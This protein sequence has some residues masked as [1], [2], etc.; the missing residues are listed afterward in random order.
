M[1]FNTHVFEIIIEINNYICQKDIHYQLRQFGL[2]AKL[3]QW[4]PHDLTSKQKK[5]IKSLE[6]Y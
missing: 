5:R 6:N 2:F 3:G 1:C 4:A